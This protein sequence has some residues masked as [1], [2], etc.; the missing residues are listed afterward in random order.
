[1]PWR[2]V[3]PEG[4]ASAVLAAALL[5]GCGSATQSGGSSPTGGI[6]PL[7]PRALAAVV[8]EHTGTPSSAAAGRDMDEAGKGV[9]AEVELRYG[10]DGE[11]DGDLLAVGVGT[12]FEKGIGDCASLARTESYAGCVGTADGMVFWE[13]E[14]PGE[15]PGVVYVLASKADTDVLFFY[16]GPAITGDPRELD[17][18]ISVADL[19]AIAADPRVD[20]TTSRD[21]IEAGN[22]IEFW[23]GGN[24]R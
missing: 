2:L 23:D 14:A 10:A 7:T 11:S 19:F 8:T 16:S 9:V 22:D 3:N 13:A 5:A 4:A 18:P 20:V 24:G 12:D 6:E 21:A 1:M 17:M 15:D